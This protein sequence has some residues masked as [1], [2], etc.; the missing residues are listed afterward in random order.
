[1]NHLEQLKKQL[2]V[3]P[4]IQERERVAVVIKGDKKPRKPMVPIEKKKTEKNIGDELEEIV[5]EEE[6]DEKE[7]I[8]YKQ[9]QEITRHPIIVDK[10]DIGYDRQALLKRLAESKK[11][12]VTIKPIVEMEQKIVEPVAPTP[13]VKK[14]K[15]I[16]IKKPLIIEDEEE[17]KEENGDMK[18][19]GKLEEEEEFIL[20]PKKKVEFKEAVEEVIPVIPPKEKKRKTEKPEKGIAKLGPE[21]V[22]E[23]GDTEITSRLPRKLPPVNIK[24]GNYVMNNRETFVNFINSLFSE[25]KKDLEENKESISCDTIGKTSTNFSLLTLELCKIERITLFPNMFVDTFNFF[26]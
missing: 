25:Y 19:E 1:M 17:L 21:V 18:E 9:E 14:A 24:V 23:M 11:T 22:V 3:K 20:K 4:N 26:D 15:K 2:M 13:L 10:T 16:E 7:E 12:K 8:E 6:K 5:A